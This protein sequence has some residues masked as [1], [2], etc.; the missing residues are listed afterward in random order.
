MR[1][2]RI[3]VI[4][5]WGAG[6]WRRGISLH[7]TSR[8]HQE[9]VDHCPRNSLCGQLFDE[10]NE[11]YQ[12]GVSLHKCYGVKGDPTQFLVGLFS[13]GLEFIGMHAFV[14]D[15]SEDPSITPTRIRE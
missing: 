13:G 1:N 8:R 4:F 10:G 6:T 9:R 11:A 5:P 12:T 7:G 3:I 14:C 15:P 2:A